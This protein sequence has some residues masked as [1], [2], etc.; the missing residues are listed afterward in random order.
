MGQG[1][2]PADDGDVDDTHAGTDESHADA[3]DAR[4][5]ELLRARTATAYPALRELRRR[6]GAAVHAYAGLCTASESSARQL[7]MQ[8]FTTA[9]R[10]TARGVEPQ[11]PLRH[12]LLL[13]TARLAASW[14]QDQRSAGLDPALLLILNTSRLPGG[15]VPPMLEAFRSLPSRAQGLIWYG[16][17]DGE[18]ED[19]TATFLGASREDVR[20]GTPQA[21]Q[22]LAQACLRSRLA[23]SD[24]PRCGD[25]RRLIEESARPENPRYSADLHAHMAHCPHCTAAYEDLT[26]LR[27]APRAAL[28]EGLLPWGGAAYIRGAAPDGGP[29]VASESRGHG[30][31]PPGRRVL[32][33][34]A[35]LGVALAPLL[36]LLLSPT[37]SR[38]QNEAA[39]VTPTSPPVTVT[40]TATVSAPP[41][42]PTSESPSP[43]KTSRPPVTPSPTPKRK[44]K[45]KPSPTPTP[46]FAPPGS[47]Y[48]QVVNA[49]TGRCL[50][51][52]D[53]WFDNGTDVITATCTGSPTQRWRV[54]SDRGVLQSA[55]D[56]D[57]CLDSRGSVDRGVGIWTCDSVYGRNGQNLRFD[58]DSDGVIRPEIAIETGLTAH[59]DDWPSLDPL[60]GG[61]AQRWHAGA[62]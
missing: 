61:S 39:T 4:L 36:V 62:A 43:T 6:H 57:Y 11:V 44:P 24:D 51:V 23:A 27:D 50:D 60:N 9:A 58:V 34:S 1:V 13:L 45:P 29:P 46:T 15:P 14:A 59:G 35:A 40:A 41:P 20:Y 25:F 38:H 31:R 37:G 19:T 49:A 5:T 33:T 22:T 21:L 17:L 7:A 30:S 3:P 10:E 56:P 12:Q 8:V 55:A 42:S 54:D 26:A 32:L 52:D 28:A 18:P 2:D 16:I 53:G 48:A 47:A